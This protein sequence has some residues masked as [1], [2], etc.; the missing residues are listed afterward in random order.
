MILGSR[1][2]KPLR[3]EAEYWKR[4]IVYIDELVTQWL[5]LQNNWRYLSKIFEA[6]DIS[7]SLPEEVKSFNL[8]DKQYKTLMT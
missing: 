7:N 8:V 4:A 6:K 2:V 3:V 1:F 5:T